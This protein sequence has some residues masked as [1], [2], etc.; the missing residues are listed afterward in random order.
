MDTFRYVLA[1]VV[2][3]SLAPAVLLWFLIHPLGAF[4]RR[5]G[6]WTTYTILGVLTVLSMAGVFALRGSL[7]ARDWGTNYVTLGLGL[8]AMTLGTLIALKRK[9]HLTFPIL[10]GLPQVSARQYPGKLLTEGIYGRLRHPRYVEVTLWVLGY[11]LVTNFP[12]LYAAAVLT[13]P[14]LL[15]IVVLEER[16]LEERFGEEWREYAARVPRFVPEAWR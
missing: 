14:A 10:A 9:R 6:P 5:L 1:L 16:E 7:M 3:M 8:V 11:A 12:S 4:W 2:L 13:P 15:I